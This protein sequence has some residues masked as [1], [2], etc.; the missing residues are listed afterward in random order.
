VIGAAPD[1]TWSIVE[2]GDFNGD[3]DADILWRQSNTGTLAEW[4]MNGSTISS[5]QVLGAAPDSTWS[6]Q[7]KPTNV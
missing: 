7:A 6:T 1:S 2:I 4:Q 5:S 3:G